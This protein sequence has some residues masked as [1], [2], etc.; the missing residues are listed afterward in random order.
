MPRAP[1]KNDDPA[2]SSPVDNDQPIEET[3][4]P[5]RDEG[6]EDEDLANEIL[7]EQAAVAEEEEDG[8]D[9]FGDNMEDDYRHIPELD[10][11]D[12][13]DVDQNDYSDMDIEDRVA[14]ERELK[15][16][17]KMEGRSNI[18]GKIKDSLLY[19]ELS[20]DVDP[21]EQQMHRSKRKFHDMGSQGD[22]GTDEPIESIENLDVMKGHGLREWVKMIGPR[23]EIYNRFKNFLKTIVDENGHNV[24]REK[25]RYMVEANH[26]SLIVDYNLLYQSEEV[27]A[28]F[29]VEAPLEMLQIFDEAAKDYVFSLYPHYHKI[30]KE[31]HVR[32]S[33]LPLVEEL[34]SL[35]QLHL[36]Q[37]VRTNG[38]ITSSTSVLPQ[39]SMIKYN[40]L[41]CSFILGPFYQTLEKEV[42]PQTCP[43][44]QSAGPFEI[45][46]EQTIYSNYQ[47]ITIQ[48]SPGKVPPGRLP[49]SKDAILMGDMCD[50]C[51]PGDEIVRKKII[52]NSNFNIQILVTFFR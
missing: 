34:R 3:N 26:Q 29:L 11:Y 20:E 52:L 31:I 4:E 35:R 13:E 15:K 1:R 40:C 8:E 10:K 45:N 38:V 37:L 14:A 44:C 9:L 12:A 19:S 27:L 28:Y 17:D 33:D 46:M 21:N 51:K 32:I 6:D 48:E 36:N 30:A 23:T 25:I 2:P 5:F 24:F 39:L 42:K 47:R 50:S 22:Q 43:E 41:K 16:R 7:G 49:R 18:R